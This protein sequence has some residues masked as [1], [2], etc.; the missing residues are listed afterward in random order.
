MSQ[1]YEKLTDR[2]IDVL[3]A[4]RVMGLHLIKPPF[5]P[6]DTHFSPGVVATDIAQEIWRA[7]Y[8]QGRSIPGIAHH[9]TDDN[10][11]RLVRD[12]IASLGVEAIDKYEKALAEVVYSDESMIATKFHGASFFAFT[13]QDA[14]P[15]QQCLAALAALEAQAERKEK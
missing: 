7:T 15:R 12:R 11:V 1:D 13:L 8:P 4:E 3:V 5:I 14:T 2:E 9:S 10:A 6:R